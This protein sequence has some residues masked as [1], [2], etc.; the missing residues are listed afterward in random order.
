MSKFE[1][2]ALCGEHLI[3]PDMALENDN[4]NLAL[5]AR[6]DAEVVRVL[7]EEF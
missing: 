4:L 2:M 6:D 3:D 5:L 1:F 7:T